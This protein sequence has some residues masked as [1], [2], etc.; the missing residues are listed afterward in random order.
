M[1][2][3]SWPY[4]KAKNKNRLDKGKKSGG[5]GG[6]RRFEPGHKDSKA[7][8]SIVYSLENVLCVSHKVELEKANCEKKSTIYKRNSPTTKLVSFILLTCKHLTLIWIQNISQ[9]GHF[10]IR[11]IYI[12]NTYFCGI[13][14]IICR[15]ETQRMS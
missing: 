3:G 7:S 12:L 11:A 8:Q 2:L 4:S 1:H 14:S 15:N 10:L 5:W 13:Y 6:D 9:N